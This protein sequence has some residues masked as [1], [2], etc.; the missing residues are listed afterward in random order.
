MKEIVGRRRKKRDFWAV[1]GFM[2]SL[3]G[4]ILTL[5]NPV[6]SSQTALS[7]TGDGIYT[8]ISNTSIT[9]LNENS[10]TITYR[11][12]W[13]TN[14]A[15]LPG[16]ISRD[17]VFIRFSIADYEPL[18]NKISSNIPNQFNVETNNIALTGIKAIQS[19]CENTQQNVNLQDIKIKNQK[20]VCSL[21]TINN[22][23][24]ISCL[25]SATAYVEKNGQTIPVNFYGN[26]DGYADIT[27]LKEINK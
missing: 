15:S 26:V 12:S 25:A 27:F 21:V 6:T 23:P 11:L 24:I 5:F 9:K 22:K 4:I 14:N 19:P 17:N 1:G 2:L 8:S 20:A 13:I 10:Q 7:T 18:E 16:C 3:I